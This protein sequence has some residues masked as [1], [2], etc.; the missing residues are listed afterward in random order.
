M[1]I[2]II[3]AGNMGKALGASIVRAGHDVALSSLH[4]EHAEAVAR[5]VGAV[6][7]ASNREAVDGA[8]LVILA[9]PY[10]AID[11]ILGDLGDALG[12]KVVVDITNPLK[13]DMSGLA[14]EGS[15]EAERIQARLPGAAVVKAFNTAF[16]ARQ[17][18]PVV[19]GVPLD[20]LV[21]GDDEEAKKKVLELV[22]A[23]GF[24]PIDAGGLRMA[25]SLEEM[26]FLNITL[27]IRN[28]W[29]WQAGWKLVGP[30][31]DFLGPAAKL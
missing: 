5:E 29:P 14:T 26:A 25:R 27:Q 8:D 15:S 9:V 23:I 2:A 4:P 1:R 18:D 20:G 10:T 13:A 3:G 28:G 31:S 24:R 6:A 30:T 11:G 22:A 19:D 16:A 7:A 17:V 12:G 21:A